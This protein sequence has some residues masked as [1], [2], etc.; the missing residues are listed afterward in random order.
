MSRAWEHYEPIPSTTF[1]VHRDG[2]RE[3]IPLEPP[4]EG[5]LVVRVHGATPSE[6]GNR[7]AVVEI[8]AVQEKDE[9]V[10]GDRLWLFDRASC[11]HCETCRRGHGPSCPDYRRTFLP[12]LDVD[13]MVV[14]SWI[15]KRASVRLPV[16]LSTEAALGMGAHAWVLRALRLHA[17]TNPLRI[18]VLGGGASTRFLG[19]LLETRWPDAR[20][21]LRSDKAA[22]GFHAVSL[23]RDV[24][25]GALEQ[26]A[27]LVLCL[28]DVAADDL[29]GLV[30]PGV[31]VVL[32]GEGELSM[33]GSLADLEATVAASRGGTPRDIEAFRKQFGAF[34]ERWDSLGN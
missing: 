18:L 25:L 20:R 8:V 15:A 12:H 7:G 29:L 22:P 23:D 30:C 17:P 34:S 21:I 13:H 2:R 4:R 6:A 31:C 33:S 19:A 11:G 1:L 28:E 9:L 32:A 3:E 24:L 14:P 26:P 5:E 10:L 27:D 16:A